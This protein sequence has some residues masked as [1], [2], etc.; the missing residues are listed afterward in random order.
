MPLDIAEN[1]KDDRRNKFVFKLYKMIGDDDCQH[2]ISWA[3]SGTSVIVSNVEEFSAEV[4][5]KHFKHN[6]FSSFIR[7][8]NM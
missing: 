1:G 6:N 2:L 8:L 3:P 4:L 5:G 7:Q